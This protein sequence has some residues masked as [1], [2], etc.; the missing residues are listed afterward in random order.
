MDYLLKLRVREGELEKGI[1]TAL[2]EEYQLKTEVT[3]APEQIR[4]PGLD[5]SVLGFNVRDLHTSGCAAY[6]AVGYEDAETG[7]YRIHGF[8]ESY[9]PKC[10]VSYTFMPAAKYCS[11]CGT[12]IEYRI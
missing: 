3:R 5:V 8:L 6:I 9:C 4:I 2:E 7:K 1:R 11:K 10:N 12:T